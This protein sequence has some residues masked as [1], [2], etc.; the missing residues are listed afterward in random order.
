VCQQLGQ[1]KARN[2]LVCC[3]DPQ[4][5]YV[6]LWALKQQ[7]LHI[8][9]RKKAGLAIAAAARRELEDL[10]WM[11][12]HHYLDSCNR[13]RIANMFGQA[14]LGGHLEVVQ[15]LVSEGLHIGHYTC[16]AAARGGQLEVLKCLRQNHRCTSNAWL[17]CA[18]IAGGPHMHVI[19]WALDEGCP[20]DAS[21]CTAAAAKGDLSLLQ[22]LRARGVPWDEDTCAAAAKGGDLKGAA[23]APGGGLPMG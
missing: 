22:Q 15:L 3:A 7:G 4:S 9:P 17:I 6:P 13:Y 5:S 10:Q 18:A 11:I 2:V 23:V 19:S 14:A 12:E 20:V 21:V 1:S 16:A 8:P